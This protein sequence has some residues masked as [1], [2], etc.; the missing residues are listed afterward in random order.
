MPATRRKG[1]QPLLGKITENG[2]PEEA[3]S[4]VLTSRAF[5]KRSQRAQ[6]TSAVLIVDWWRSGGEEEDSGR[7]LASGTSPAARKEMVAIGWQ[8]EQVQWQGLVRSRVLL[9]PV[10][11]V[12]HAQSCPPSLDHAEP[13]PSYKM[14]SLWS[15]GTLISKS[16]NCMSINPLSANAAICRR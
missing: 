9:S 5:P 16:I 14:P 2:F 1:C 6:R 12:K 8:E 3:R 13:N 11:E 10:S 4:A 7:L 15:R